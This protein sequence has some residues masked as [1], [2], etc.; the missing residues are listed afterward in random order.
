MDDKKHYDVGIIGWWFA[1]NYGSG[2]TYYALGKILQ[3]KGLSSVMLPVSKLN[4]TPWE[5]ETKKTIE[6]I[7]KYFPIADERPIENNVEYNEMCDTFILGSDQLWTKL[8]IELLGYTFFLDFAD[9]T[10]KKIAYATSLGKASFEGTPEQKKHIHDL[11]ST[12]DYISVREVSGIQACK[13]NFGLDV[14][15]DLDPVF[16]CET[17][18]YDLLA[19]SC[20]D[21]EPNEEYIFTY[22]LDTS[23]EIQKA[24][25]YVA[26]KLGIRIVSVLDIKSGKSKKD[27]WHV[28][29][30][31][32]DASI[33]E[34]VYYIKH[35]KLM[36]T[37]SHHGACFAMIYNR[38]LITIANAGRG[39]TRF[40]NLFNL[41]ELTDRLVANVNEIYESEH[42]FTPI[43]YDKV[44]AIIERERKASY[45]RFDKVLAQKNKPEIFSVNNKEM[46]MGCAACA[47]A[48]PVDAIKMST[49]EYGY[50]CP[51]V[52]MDKCIACGKCSNVCPAIE[53]PERTN[54][55]EPQCFA[56]KAKD[57]EIL[58]ASSSG[59]V[60]TLLAREVLKNDGVVV[61]AAW[62]DSQV[63]EHIMVESIDELY[64]LQKSKYLQS[65]L[66]DIH[67][68]VKEKLE[69]G[70]KVLFTGCPCQIA[71][72][73]KYLGKEYENLLLVDL[74]CG[75][76]PSPLFF[77]KYLEDSFPQGIDKYT[78]RN[79]Q[80]G[81]DCDTVEVMLK[82]G[83]SQIRRGAG[84]DDYQ[85][86]FHNHTMC[87]PHCEKCKYQEVAR[88]G[89]LTIGDFW[90]YSKFDPSIDVSKGLSVVLCNNEKGKKFFESISD[91][92]IDVKKEVPLNWLGG[93]GYALG[94]H[95]YAS[96]YRDSFYEAIKKTSFSEAVEH[97]FSPLSNIEYPSVLEKSP[98]QFNTTQLHFKMDPNMWE[99]HFINSK[100]VL[101][102]KSNNPPLGNYAS[103]QLM[104]SLRSGKKY[105]FTIRFKVK[106]SSKKLTFHI[107]EALTKKIQ[108]IHTH[109][110][111]SKD[112]ENWVEISEV[113]VPNANVYSEFMIGAAQ[114]SGKNSYF[115]IDYIDISE[116]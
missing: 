26:D 92:S 97:A 35:C 80:Y 113:F 77:K 20:G 54:L 13:E 95:N 60:F 15:R 69:Q 45:E 12:F 2:L 91:E 1:S 37:D 43:D 9:E 70:K 39:L 84:D 34:F 109:D 111:T 88:F 108:I 107:K 38:Q 65:Y 105:R 16:L 115:V 51:E 28:G 57:T 14:K 75:N 96:K 58:D 59:G 98:L 56:F 99:E 4:R 82:D 71:G 41:F 49:D 24:I 76:A 102:T 48:C 27:S 29:E 21:L 10:K 44:N 47:N 74:L 101:V 46:C 106:T 30:L 85:R 86:V 55:K 31:K 19:D 23:E 110:V 100:V 112:A 89:D 103:L 52:D 78:F 72:L 116:V 8:A 3:N 33:E 17:E 53:T 7:G 64:K 87:A 40:T 50:Y 79:K 68:R 73:K 63:V 67:K 114:I 22:I 25:E 66:G 93:N 36:I 94:G 61:G 5:P 42:L 83:T 104:H 32:E 18:N 11:L 81:L 6:F 90:G 62:T